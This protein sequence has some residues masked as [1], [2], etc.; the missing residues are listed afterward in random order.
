LLL[1]A[2][3]FLDR[4]EP[5]GRWT[6]VIHVPGGIRPVAHVDASQTS[7]PRDPAVQSLRVVRRRYLLPKVTSGILATLCTIL[8]SLLGN[9]E[10]HPLY[11]DVAKVFS[12]KAEIDSVMLRRTVA[13]S[14]TG[15]FVLLVYANN[16]DGVF[17]VPEF[18]HAPVTDINSFLA[19]EDSFAQTI[20]TFARRQI[21]SPSQVQL[22]RRRA[23]P[24]PKYHYYGVANDSLDMM[25]DWLQVED[26]ARLYQKK[27]H[28]LADDYAVALADD[29]AAVRQKISRIV[30]S[31]TGLLALA[32]VAVWL[33]ER[34]D[35][36]W[37]DFVGTDEGLVV[38]F[39]RLRAMLEG[40]ENQTRDRFSLVDL[41]ELIATKAHS[42]FTS[43]LLGSRV[44]AQAAQQLA[45]NIVERLI[46]R[47][48]V[49]RHPG[50]DVQAWYRIDP[51]LVG[52]SR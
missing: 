44:G 50:K 8:Y 47:G 25:Q 3:E 16:S 22:R 7:T 13:L 9:L 15:D 49:S 24:E 37:I 35:Q 51:E 5:A 18:R 33:R 14:N 32:C 20:Q 45:P 19:L 17:P 29:R 36:D 48:V 28:A 30:A 27:V 6:D 31:L 12:H 34:S 1:D 41:A 39:V 42:P 4:N 46:A 10:N 26:E 38:V 21:V 2:L 43:V 11:R 23:N 40:K 52:G